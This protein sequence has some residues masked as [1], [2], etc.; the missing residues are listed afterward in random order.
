MR[1]LSALLGRMLCLG[2]CLGLA[3][4]GVRSAAWLPAEP[5]LAAALRQ[6]DWLPPADTPQLLRLEARLQIGS[7][8]FPLSAVLRRDTRQLR[9]VI[10]SDMG[11]TLCDMEVT[12]VGHT[13]H[14]V[15]PDLEKR[16]QIQGHVARTLRRIFLAPRLAEPFSVH[17]RGEE[18]RLVSGRGDQ[19]LERIHDATTLR[20]VRIQAPEQG[21]TLSLPPPDPDAD[22][23]AKGR[24]EYRD[25]SGGYSVQALLLSLEPAP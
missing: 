19:R 1:P 22:L 8:G 15:L 16:G 7:R 10:M 11:L 12:P 5:E 9:A 3:A 4:C 2:L 17:R 25:R 13:T 24:F 23:P 6:V 21:W 14:K 18:L 20:L